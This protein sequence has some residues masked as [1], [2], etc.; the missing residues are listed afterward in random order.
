MTS[1]ARIPP[2][3]ESDRARIKQ[4]FNAELLAD[5][6]QRRDFSHYADRTQLEP[7]RAS[8][9]RFY[10]HRDN[11]ASVLAVAHLDTV[12]VGGKSAGR[13][14][15]IH[16]AG[17][18]LATST[19]LDDRLGAYL[20]LE[21]LPALGVKLDVLLTTDEECAQSTAGDFQPTKPY[22]WVVEFDRGGTDVVMYQYDTPELRDMVKA[23]GARVGHGSYS[24]IADLEH[25]GVSALNW[26]V[27]YRDYHGPRAHA[28]L[29]DT[30]RMVGYFLKFYEA[31]KDVR[32]PYFPRRRESRW[33]GVFDPPR[34]GWPRDLGGWDRWDDGLEDVTPDG[35]I[36]L[37][38]PPDD[39]FIADC[40]CVVMVGEE[41]VTFNR[42]TLCLP[43][44]LE[45]WGDTQEVADAIEVWQ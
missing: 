12:Q 16:T 32:L 44:A 30:F 25:L 10:W 5:I 31:N 9:D 35:P 18:L 29:N 41:Y 40:G 23:T 27:G 26:G 4:A 24:D 19:A 42:E 13:C 43:C 45:L 21:L 11:G 36:A 7:T 28:W 22:N 15:V 6:C 2:G 34:G 8:S 39:G 17:G 33:G 1:R 38:G 37:D 20:I 3:L 14:K